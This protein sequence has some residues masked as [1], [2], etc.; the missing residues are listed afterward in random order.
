MGLVNIF[1]Q[2]SFETMGSTN[3]VRL[4]DSA[5]VLDMGD[6]WDLDGVRK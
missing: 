5:T 4:S 6:G 2:D 3:L 1:D